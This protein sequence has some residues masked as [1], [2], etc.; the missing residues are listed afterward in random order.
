MLLCY[1]LEWGSW[2]E[3]S[4]CSAGTCGLIGVQKRVRECNIKF[5]ENVHFCDGR[6]QEHR[7]CN[8]DS[9]LCQDDTTD[10]CEC[11]AEHDIAQ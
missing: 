1:S 6:D 7:T 2:S 3:W 11:V 8:R 9:E 5:E 10:P 4:E